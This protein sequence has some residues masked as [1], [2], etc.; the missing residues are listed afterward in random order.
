[1][2]TGGSGDALTGIIAGLLAQGLP[3]L[4]AA[5]SGVFLHGLAGDC[6]VRMRGARE[7]LIATD[8]IE[9]LADAYSALRATASSY[10]DEG[11][12]PWEN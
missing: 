8:L 1:M 11:V 4:E 7:G 6:A 10:G 5:A 12:I 9:S 2:A 3:A